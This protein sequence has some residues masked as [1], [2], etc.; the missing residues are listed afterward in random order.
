[1][2][3]IKRTI[4]A[5][6]A[7]LTLVSSYSFSFNADK[8]TAVAANT[9]IEKALDWAVAIAKDD[10]HGYSQS[11]RNGGVD[12]DCSSLVTYSLIKAG[13]ITNDV[14]TN[15]NALTTSNMRAVLT[16]HGFTWI[17][18]SKIKNT[19]NLKRGDILLSE[20]NHTEMYL[21][22][23]K[24]VG[25]HC[26]YGTDK[27]NPKKH[28]KNGKE[29]SVDSYW[30]DNWNGV[31]RYNGSESEKKTTATTKKRSAKTTTTAVKKTTAATKKTTKTTKTTAATKKTTTTTAKKANEEIKIEIKNGYR[32]E[33]KYVYFKKYTG[34]S[35]SIVD[36]L[37]YI[38]E[39]SSYNTRS[40]IASLN[41]ISNYKGTAAQNT[42]MLNLLKNGKLIKSKTLVGTP[43]RV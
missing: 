2:K 24:N 34:K 35:S 15:G 22:N 9:K 5:A 13:I 39:N 20:G 33:Y 40:Q 7:A 11:K 31:L 4:C 21:G 19:S 3:N 23:N 14:L 43:H 1:M 42:K 18:W 12:Y 30:Y 6:L 27:N 8:T 37:N 25:A 10:T 36:A 29:I 41:G 38:K 26:D 32:Y 28:D 17:P 16:K